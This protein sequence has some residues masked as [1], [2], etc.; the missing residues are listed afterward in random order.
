M[1]KGLLILFIFSFNYGLAQQS[2]WSATFTPALV[3]NPEINYGWQIGMCYDVAPRFQ[4]LSSLTTGLGILPLA[5]PVTTDKNYFRI[6]SEFRYINLQ[7]HDWVRPYVGLQTSLVSRSW[8]SVN[9]G[10]YYEGTFQSDSVVNFTSARI[11]SQ[12][13]ITTIQFGV[14]TEIL[15]QVYIDLSLGLGTKWVSTKYTEVTDPVKYER[16]SPKERNHF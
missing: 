4:A 9:S 10:S 12:A 8:K 7:S 11:N 16:I 15:D 2:K 14:N 3:E 6:K 5:K 13:I 1:N